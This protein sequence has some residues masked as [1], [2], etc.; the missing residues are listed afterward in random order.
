M[1]NMSKDLKIEIA[2]E[3]IVDAINQINAEYELPLLI[4]ELIL[5][6][7]SNEVSN[8]RISNLKIERETLNKNETEV[9]EW[10]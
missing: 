2:K 9:L 3:K 7:I 6:S 1:S 8:M 4:L 5:N 10:I